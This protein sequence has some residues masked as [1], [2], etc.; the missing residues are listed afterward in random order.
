MTYKYN[1]VLQLLDSDRQT[2]LMI[3][4]NSG[5]WHIDNIGRSYPSNNCYM[6]LFYITYHIVNFDENEIIIF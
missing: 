2:I 5:T 3:W 1:R 6:F 4:M